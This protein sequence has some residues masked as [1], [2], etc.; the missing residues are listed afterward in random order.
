MFRH[1]RSELRRLAARLD[2]ER[3][4]VAAS[5]AGLAHAGRHVF[6]D[7]RALLAPFTAGALT[8]AAAQHREPRRGGRFSARELFAAVTAM[9]GLVEAFRAEIL[10]WL[11]GPAAAADVRPAHHRPPDDAP[12]ATARD[13]AEPPES[14]EPPEPPELP[15]PQRLPLG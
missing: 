12:E 11:A 3:A 7:K 9:T 8:G 6:D 14:P 2:V 10:P 1:D 5:R 4:R 13:D 15:W